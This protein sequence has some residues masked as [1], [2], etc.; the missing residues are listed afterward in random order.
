MNKFKEELKKIGLFLIAGVILVIILDI[1]FTNNLHSALLRMFSSRNIIFDLYFI[2]FPI[3]VY[4][5]KDNIFGA[6][7]RVIS[8]DHPTDGSTSDR[9]AITSIIY[10]IVALFTGFIIG[11]I[12]GL[13]KAIIKLS[14][15][16]SLNN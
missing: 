8:H 16:K 5:N 13:I 10:L 11:P 3:G 4:Y 7:C 15:L 14:S 2:F 12:I 9:T 6:F 1:G